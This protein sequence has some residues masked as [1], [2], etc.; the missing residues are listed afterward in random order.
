MDKY[1][2]HEILPSPGNPRNSEGSFLRA[3]N[4][5]IL[6]AYSRFTGGA[7]D[8]ESCDIALIRSSDNGMTFGEPVI[9]ARAADFGVSN[10]M[11]VSGLT[12]PDGRLGFWFLIKENDRTSTLGRAISSD[13][14]NFTSERC[15]CL[16]PK[17]Y[18]VVNNDRLELMSDGRLAIPAAAHRRVVKDGGQL[19][20]DANATLFVLTSAD[21]KC[22]CDSGVRVN[23][24][25]Y[26]LNRHA[27]I[28]EPGIYERPDG[29]IIMWARTT[30]GSQ[31]VSVSFDGMKSFTAPEP[32]EFTSPCS[33]LELYSH[34]GSLFAAYNPIP[35]YNG[36]CEGF[37]S[38]RTPL[39]LRVS[40]DY[41]SSFG[42]LNIIGEDSDRGYCYPAMFAPDDR[43]LLLAC[44]RGKGGRCLTET[45]IYRIPLNELT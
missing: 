40:K 43:H 45:G 24:P 28:Q 17:D 1:L 7:G 44:C 13:G 41:G 18:Y 30:L 35:N 10:I 23:L 11:S 27:A 42:K 4:G 25:Q 20:F 22:F 12:L 9:I 32:S 31:Y 19:A 29:N 33:P 21:G 39:A 34:G 16:F 37:G 6:F 5:D 2:I 15:E 38:D 36:R 26:V 3:P 14:V 8:D